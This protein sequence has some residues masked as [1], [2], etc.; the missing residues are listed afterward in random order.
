MSYQDKYLKYQDKYLKYKE[1]YLAL[2]NNT[3]I[4]IHTGGANGTKPEVI[5]LLGGPGS[6]KG[7]L[8][9][10][11]AETFEYKPISAG[12]LLREEKE[13]PGSKNGA[14]IKEYQ[15]EGKIVPSE[16]TI[17]LIKAKILELSSNGFHKFLLDGFPRND[18]NLKLWNEIV[19]DS[20]K[21][22]FVIFLNCSE[23]IM[24]DRV[25]KRGQTSGRADDNIE[26][27]TKRIK[28]YNE[29]TL[30]VIK[31]YKKMKMVKEV[32]S[33][34]TPE[35]IF[36][37]VK[38]L[39]ANNK[40]MK[41]SSNSNKNN[42]NNSNNSNNKY[43]IGVAGASGCGKTY[44]SNYL[45]ELIE[46][47]FSVEI[48]SCDDYYKSYSEEK[49][50]NGKWI[51]PNDRDP[52][53]NWDVPDVLDLKLLSDNLSDFK[54]NIDI[55][56]PDYDFVESHRR[57]KPKKII[58]SKDI[59]IIIVEG[60]YVLYDDDLR[61]KFNLKIF[62]DADNEVCLGRRIFRDIVEGRNT[63]KDATIEEKNKALEQLIKVYKKNIRPSY[64]KYID[65]TKVFAD[66]IINSEINYK[67]T[68]TKT[69]DIILKEVA[70]S[71]KK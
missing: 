44:F 26:T 8:G 62:I 61:S 59:Q 34:K 71:V 22:K 10:K 15:A 35:Q 29:Q 17:G 31:Y 49:K 42:S 18:E 7:T 40:I 68:D 27:V 21:L 58:K 13:R 54:K 14:L 64:I 24:I 32:D 25:L 67:T 23:K 28:V 52:N 11:I 3:A 12:D 1:K 60:L 47:D 50:S 48:I 33:S 53:F 70:T 69:I 55:S 65:P 30:P 20:I 41:G 56:I 39:F 46:K 36:N 51:T 19:G 37:I 57:E 63:P 4:K 2:K 5:F 16:I 43:I 45:K 66:F 9:E 6:G 38:K